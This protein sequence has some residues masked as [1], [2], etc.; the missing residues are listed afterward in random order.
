MRGHCKRVL[1]VK[2]RAGAHSCCSRQTEGRNPIMEE[3]HAWGLL[4]G[5]V[6]VYTRSGPRHELH[7]QS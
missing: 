2:G 7:R 6:K 3:L 5:S 1:N 4:G